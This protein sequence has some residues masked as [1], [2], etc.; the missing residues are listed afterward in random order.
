MK[1][2]LSLIVLAM[3]SVCLADA[4][5]PTT[6]PAGKQEADHA[7]ARAKW[8]K[9]QRVNYQEWARAKLGITVVRNLTEEEKDKA[10]KIWHEELNK[11]Y[12]DGWDADGDGKVTQEEFQQVG[13]GKAEEAKRQEKEMLDKYDKNHDGK[14]DESEVALMRGD[15]I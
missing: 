4:G 15:Q 12:I 2:A 1:K 6:V 14:L 7:A 8:Y 5:A 3:A 13:A 11:A 9:L 10:S